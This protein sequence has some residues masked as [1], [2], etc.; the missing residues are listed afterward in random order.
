[1][2]TIILIQQTTQ[3]TCYWKIVHQCQIS[4]QRVTSRNK[5]K[6]IKIE[7][8]LD[9]KSTRQKHSKMMR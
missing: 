8:G 3:R 7:T 9:H 2:V 5:R 1:M 4:V 6:P